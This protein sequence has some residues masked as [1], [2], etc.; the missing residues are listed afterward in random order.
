[1]SKVP[2]APSDYQPLGITGKTRQNANT[3]NV[4]PNCRTHRSSLQEMRSHSVSG[5]D[6]AIVRNWHLSGV[7]TICPQRPR[8]SRS[9]AYISCRR[10][11]APWRAAR[12]AVVIDDVGDHLLAVDVDVLELQVGIAIVS[13]VHIVAERESQSAKEGLS[14]TGH[15]PRTR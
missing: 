1:M 13:S 5:Y 8:R 14:S 10:R 9:D 7:C 12:S 2:K 4:W 11:H 6:R 15:G 3:G